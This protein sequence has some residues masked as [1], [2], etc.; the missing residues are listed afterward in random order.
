MIDLDRF[1]MYN[2]RHGHPAG[3]RLLRQ[4]ADHWMQALRAS[5]FMARYGGEEFVVLLPDCTP[6]DARIVIE[7]MREATPDG[8]TCSAG[9]AALEVGESA[10]HLVARADAALYAAKGAGRDRTVL[11]NERVPTPSL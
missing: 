9:I 8:Q 3:D 2:D 6:A 7:R 5:D 10:E 11:A 4:C 1:K